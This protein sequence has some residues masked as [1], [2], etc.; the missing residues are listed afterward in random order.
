MSPRQVSRHYVEQDCTSKIII[1]RKRRVKASKKGI[2]R[3]RGRRKRMK[4][5]KRKRKEEEE[6]RGERK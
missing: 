2:N 1:S 4:R 3:R 6:E 5:K